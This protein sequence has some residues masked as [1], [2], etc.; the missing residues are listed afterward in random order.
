MT[1]WNSGVVAS[2]L[3]IP[4]PPIIIY[5]DDHD[6][7]NPNNNNP[8][9]SITWRNISISLL[10]ILIL[11]VTFVALVGVI[12]FVKR[13]NSKRALYQTLNASNPAEEEDHVWDGSPLLSSLSSSLL[14]TLLFYHLLIHHHHHHHHYHH[15]YHHHH[16]HHY[17]HHYNYHHHYRLITANKSEYYASEAEVPYN[18]LE[19]SEPSLG[20]GDHG[21]VHKAK[22]KGLDVAV[23]ICSFISKYINHIMISK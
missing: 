14:F 22:Y 3:N 1:G 8:S 2:I 17:H 7:Y 18:L 9:N 21:V 4:S 10:L 15:H 20:R 16:Y 5:D 13:N 11:L 6:S 19:I 12:V 23:K